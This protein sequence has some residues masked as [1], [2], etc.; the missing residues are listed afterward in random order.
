MK[1]ELMSKMMSNKRSLMVVCLFTV[2]IIL[3]AYLPQTASAEGEFTKIVVFGDSW[4]DNGFDDGYG[5]RYYSNGKLWYEYLA[6]MLGVKSVEGRAWGGALS[7]QGNYNSPAK[8]W[9]GLLW[10]VQGYTPDLETGQTLF[11][12]E[13]GINDLHDPSMKIPPSAVVENVRKAMVDL[14]GKG[15]KHIIVWNLPASITFPGYT[16]EKYEWYSY[17]A[18]KLNDAKAQFVKY[19]EL[20]AVA[21]AAEAQNHA[22]VKIYFYDTDN[23]MKEIHKKF[24]STTT[25]WG[26]SYLYP[27][28]GE[29]M[30]Y[31]EWHLMTETHKYISEQ[32][33]D[34]LQK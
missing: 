12:I 1:A 13:I 17:Y 15:A 11:A 14:I 21:V 25:K 2:T 8:T 9:S 29:Y 10:Q 30:W 5:F 20:I 19:N 34:L 28:P 16:S 32:V 6:N 3:W 7:G 18:P 22:D 27:N 31:D 24:Q 26:G 23:G 33:Y 4:S